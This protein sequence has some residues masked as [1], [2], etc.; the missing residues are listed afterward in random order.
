MYATEVNHYVFTIVTTTNMLMNILCYI[1]TVILHLYYISF[2]FWQ[3]YNVLVKLSD[4][5]IDPLI[6]IVRST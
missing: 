1:I 3:N 2:I 6:Y 4:E 5:Y